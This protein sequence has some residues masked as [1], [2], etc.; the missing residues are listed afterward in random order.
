MGWNFD[1]NVGGVEKMSTS[2]DD[3]LVIC[4]FSV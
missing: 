2:A 4:C 3:A 1:S